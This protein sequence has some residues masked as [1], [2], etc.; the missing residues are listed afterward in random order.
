MNFFLLITSLLGF[1]LTLTAQN[2]PVPNGD[3]ENWKPF[4][5]CPSIDSLEGYNIYDEFIFTEFGECPTYPIIKKSTDKYSGNYALEMKPYYDGSNYYSSGVYSSLDLFEESIQGIPFTSK[6]TKLTGYYK[7]NSGTT[8]DDFVISVQ[9]SD[10]FGYSIG[11]GTIIITESTNAYTKFEILLAYASN[12]NNN[13][14]SSLVIVLLV[15]NQTFDTANPLSKAVIDNLQFE[16]PTPTSTTNY[17]ATSSINVFAA[18][19][20]IN[21][22]ENVSD[23]HVVDMT[24][25]SKMQETASTQQ[26]N[27][28]TLKSG[29]YV[30]TY[31]YNDTYFSKKI[32]LE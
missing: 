23:V 25:A 1:T 6:P 22:S 9:V 7:F 16:Y 21:F 18:N 10:R 31:M 17:S 5:F 20:N 13:A 4:S 8:G 15:G 28:A 3:F 14:P 12:N 30:V 27:V 2:Q 24:G 11:D 29:L 19:K 32:V 26:L